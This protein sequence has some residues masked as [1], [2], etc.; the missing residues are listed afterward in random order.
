M[1]Q[2]NQKD[3]SQD[4][5]IALLT[6]RIE[7]AEKTQEE[8]RERIRKLEKWVWGAGVIT[9]LITI[10]GLASAL[11]SKELEN[12]SNDT[13]EQEI[14][15]QLQGSRL[16]VFW[17]AI[18]LMSPLILGLTYTRKKELELQALILQ[19]RERGTSKKRS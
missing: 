17:T 10:V 12:G 4:Q 15:L 6:H 7:D 14:V 9:A 2:I 8:L 19:K 11:E 16:I 5:A 18:L 13:P 1:D 3:A